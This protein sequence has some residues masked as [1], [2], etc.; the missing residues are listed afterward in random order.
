MEPDVLESACDPPE[1]GRAAADQLYDPLLDHLWQLAR[2]SVERKPRLPGKRDRR[3]PGN[4][5]ELVVRDRLREGIPRAGLRRWR[6]AGSRRVCSEQRFQNKIPGAETITGPFFVWFTTNNKA[7]ENQWKL[8]DGEGNT[9]FERTTLENLTQYKDTFD[10]APGC[11][12]IIL[13]DSDHDGIGFW[14]SSQVEGETSGQ[15]RLRQ[16]GGGYLEFFPADFGKYHR[17]DFSVGFSVGVPD[18]GMIDE[19]LLLF[20]NPASEEVRIEFNGNLGDHVSVTVLDANG[21]VL[22]QVNKETVNNFLEIDLPV[23]DLK[24]G[25][26]FIQVSGSQGIRLSQFIKQ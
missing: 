13:E 23:G 18:N 24:A 8:I 15:F 11:Y 6:M 25:M 20:P 7:V 12:S 17:Y 21:R 19:E 14:Y 22:K 5:S 1:Y 4:R 16:V 26:Y 2:V 3:N 9:I 10:L